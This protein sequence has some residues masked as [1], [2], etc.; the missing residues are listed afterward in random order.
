MI[1][2]LSVSCLGNSMA[3]PRHP[4]P[5]SS[6]HSDGPGRSIAKHRGEVSALAGD[7]RGRE[8]PEIP[9]LLPLSLYP[10]SQVDRIGKIIENL[11][12]K[13]DTEKVREISE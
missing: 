1:Y 9:E 3:S 11:K 6:Q 10:A 7:K 4:L 12:S 8:R 2:W 5:P 13:T